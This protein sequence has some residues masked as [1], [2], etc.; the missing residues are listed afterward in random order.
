MS[1]LWTK[2]KLRRLK[3]AYEEAKTEIFIFDG[4]EVVKRYAQYLIEYLETL[5]LPD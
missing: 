5:N 4:V 1:N 3:K 2:S